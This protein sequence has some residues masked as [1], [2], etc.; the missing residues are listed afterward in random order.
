MNIEN[1]TSVLAQ[2]GTAEVQGWIDSWVPVIQA[3]GATIGALIFLGFAFKSLG[4]VMSSTGGGT[5][6]GG[7]GM[8]EIISGVGVI[9]LTLIFVGAAPYLAPLLVQMGEQSTSQ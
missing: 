8:R 4:K 6:G 3:F 7:N 5:G 2:G 1:S 9:V